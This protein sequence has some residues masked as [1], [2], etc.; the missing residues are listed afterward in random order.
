MNSI[1][2]VDL[3]GFPELRRHRSQ[4]WDSDSVAST[5]CPFFR[6]V[7]GFSSRYNPPAWDIV[8]ASCVGA[9]LL[10]M[11]SIN[12]SKSDMGHACSQ[13]TGIWEFRHLHSASGII[14]LMSS[15]CD[16]HQATSYASKIR[17]G[18][19]LQSNSN[20]QVNLHK[21]F[22]MCATLTMKLQRLFHQENYRGKVRD[23]FYLLKYKHRKYTLKRFY[24]L[25]VVRLCTGAFD[26][27]PGSA[28]QWKI[29]AAQ[30]TGQQIGSGVSARHGGHNHVQRAWIRRVR[31]ASHKCL[32]R[33]ARQPHC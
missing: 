3:T 19:H 24:F 29:H 2:N 26:T 23:G 6:A 30:G 22:F 17:A 5:R 10:Q 16:V 12:I 8:F 28:Q 13:G 1:I 31:R 32:Y 15:R 33:A 9:G 21:H 4:R 14:T 25:V 27:S 18:N 7:R 20:V 11:G